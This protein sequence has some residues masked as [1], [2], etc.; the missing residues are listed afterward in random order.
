M[1]KL[2]IPKWDSP[3]AESILVMDGWM[4]EDGPHGEF[5]K[6]MGNLKHGYQITTGGIV[7]LQE[8]KYLWN[9]TGTF[10]ALKISNLQNNLA[11]TGYAQ[12]DKECR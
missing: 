11:L 5:Q 10:L 3:N 4:G 1:E 12:L 8:E 2:F 9:K 6:T 7:L